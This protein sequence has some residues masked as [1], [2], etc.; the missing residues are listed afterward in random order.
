MKILSKIFS[1][2]ILSSGLTATWN[3]PVDV[4]AIGVAEEPGGPVLGVNSLNNGVAVW[5]TDVPDTFDNVVQAS[6]YTFGLGWGAP[7]IISDTS[8]NPFE[9]PVYVAQA[10]PTVA[11]NESNYVVAAWE[12]SQFIDEIQNN[13]EGIFSSFR[14]PNGTWS[15]VQ[16]VSALDIVDEDFNPENPFLDVSNSGLTVA[17][18]T[19]IRDNDRFIMANFL[20]FAGVWGT[21]IE[22]ANPVGGFREDTPRVAINSSNDAA[23]VWKANSSISFIQREIGASTFNPSTG[24][25]TTVILDPESQN[26]SL[27]RVDIDESGNAVAVWIRINGTINEVVASYF[28]FATQSWSPYIVLATTDANVNGTFDMADVVMDQFGNATAVWSATPPSGISVLFSS[29]L[30]LGGTWSFPQLITPDGF[31]DTG[32]AQ[33]E[34]SADLQGNVMVIFETNNNTLESI[35]YFNGIGWQI[36]EFI[37]APDDDIWLNVGLGSCGFALAL[38]WQDFTV[39]GAD[40]FGPSSPVV[41]LTASR[42]C[43]KFASQKICLC[44]LNWSPN[45]CALFFNIFQDGIL[46]ATLP[47]N[48]TTFTTP[49]RNSRSFSVTAVNISGIET[50]PTTIV[51]P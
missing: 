42:C 30:P 32:L 44:T 40:H 6:S 48:V 26:T 23:A 50:I 22:L 20:P 7:V 9:Q 27:P 18:W 24:L 35:S 3:P 5:A 12:G 38:W 1:L 13:V 16:R 46:I 8:L 14:L 17:V 51:S 10:D 45:P 47:G 31:L 36:P 2:L 28:T 29:R 11:I 49:C 43:E 33:I 19:E 4:S 41:N 39:M 37:Q 34:I 21:P 15:P 25:W